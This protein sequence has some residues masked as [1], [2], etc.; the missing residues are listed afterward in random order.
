MIVIITTLEKDR[1]S[2]YYGKLVASHGY[3][4][5][6]DKLVALPC[7]TP[8]SLGAKYDPK[9]GEWVLE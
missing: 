7:E 1:K 4:T 3:N 2:L 6:D 5:D 9:I 8:E